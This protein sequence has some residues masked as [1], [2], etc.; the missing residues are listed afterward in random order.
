MPTE[1]R[2]N[3]PHVTRQPDTE[4]MLLAIDTGEVL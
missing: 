1:L 3:L 4:K 2:V